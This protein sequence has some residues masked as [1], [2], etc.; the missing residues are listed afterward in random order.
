MKKTPTGIL[1]LGSLGVASGARADV[2]PVSVA[3]RLGYG[4][5]KKDITGT[6]RKLSDEVGGVVPAQLEAMLTVG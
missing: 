2:I 6:D 1:V 5:P 4:I 3:A